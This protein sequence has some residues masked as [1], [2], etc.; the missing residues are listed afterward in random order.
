MHHHGS[1]ERLKTGL[2][3]KHCRHRRSLGEG[4]AVPE[5]TSKNHRRICQLRFVCGRSPITRR[6]GVGRGT[7]QCKGGSQEEGL[8]HHGSGQTAPA[9]EGQ[10]GDVG[11]SCCWTQAAAYS[12]ISQNHGCMYAARALRLTSQPMASCWH[13]TN[14]AVSQSREDSSLATAVFEYSD[15]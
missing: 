2:V 8:D 9:G 14:P 1:E 12:W 11:W 5:R 15:S 6:R 3:K 7:S 10:G 13:L 4:F